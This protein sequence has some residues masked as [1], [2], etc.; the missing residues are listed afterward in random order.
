MLTLTEDE[1]KDILQAKRYPF[2]LLKHE[3]TA[4]AYDEHGKRYT[5]TMRT[6]S[7]CYETDNERL[8]H[9]YLDDALQVLWMGSDGNHLYVESAAESHTAGERLNQT[10]F[11][12]TLAFGFKPIRRK[13]NECLTDVGRSSSEPV[14]PTGC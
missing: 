11:E 9:S 2:S 12:I 6:V 3:E 14:A 5:P 13:R 7:F 1:L 8:F 10:K 4:I